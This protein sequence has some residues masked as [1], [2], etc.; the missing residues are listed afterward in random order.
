[1]F[2]QNKKYVPFGFKPVVHEKK[3][4]KITPNFLYFGPF[5]RP[6]TG[7]PLYLNKSESSYPKNISYQY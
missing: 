4:F 3:I 5:L 1:M 7:K 6:E 2:L